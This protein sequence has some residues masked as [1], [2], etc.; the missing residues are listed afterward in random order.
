MTEEEWLTA[1]HASALLQFIEPKVSD[2]KLYYF[3]IAC[4]RRI[5]P[6]LI[7]PA[8]VHGID[9]LERFVEGQCGEED[10]SRLSWDVE[11]AAFCVENGNGPW[12][13]AAEQLPETLLAELVVRPDYP[14]R[15]A[16]QV[17]TSAA[18]FVDRIFSTAPD[19]RRL[20]GQL[21]ELLGGRFQPVSLAHEVF[22]NPFRPVTFDPAWRTDTAVSLARVMYESRDFAAMPILADALQDGGCEHADILDHCRDPNGTHVRGCWVVDLVLGKV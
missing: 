1:E 20:R 13:N 4:A 16:R 22:G 21:A 10:I 7:H 3:D 9:V 12:Q 17:L 6:L 15:N 5:T 11:G 14:V 2:R 19:G 18:Y 8:S